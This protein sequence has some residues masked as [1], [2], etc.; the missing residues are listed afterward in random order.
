M[1]KFA[2][3]KTVLISDFRDGTQVRRK[4]GNLWEGGTCRSFTYIAD[5][6]YASPKPAIN[7][8]ISPSC[9]MNRVS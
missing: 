5:A 8:G 6:Y 1:L 3:L 7:A 2:V 9:P 4:Y